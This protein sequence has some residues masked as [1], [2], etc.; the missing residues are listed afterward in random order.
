MAP[1]AITYTNATFITFDGSTLFVAE[2]T[3]DSVLAFEGLLDYDEGDWNI[4][5][6]ASAQVDAAESV[7]LA[8]EFLSE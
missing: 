8:P 3:K 7:A 1:A 6:S 5:P 4:K 2:K